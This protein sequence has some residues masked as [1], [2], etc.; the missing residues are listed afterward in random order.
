MLPSQLY[1]TGDKLGLVL[2]YAS[3]IP[4]FIVFY[5]GSTLFYDRSWTQL[6]LFLGTGCNAGKRRISSRAPLMYTMTPHMRSR[7]LLKWQQSAASF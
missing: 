5:R 6:K 4:A 7:L 1:R 2:A 3:L